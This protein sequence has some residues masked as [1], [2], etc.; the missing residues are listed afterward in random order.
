[1]EMSQEVCP[2]SLMIEPSCDSLM[3]LL[4]SNGKSMLIAFFVIDELGNQYRNTGLKKQIKKIDY[5]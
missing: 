4:A 2:G 1:M 3:S 5:G